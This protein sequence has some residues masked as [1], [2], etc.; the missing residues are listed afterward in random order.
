MNRRSE[1]LVL[2]SRVVKSEESIAGKDASAY[3]ACQGLKGA[4]R[5]H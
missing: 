1:C 3:V 2:L 5:A 4:N